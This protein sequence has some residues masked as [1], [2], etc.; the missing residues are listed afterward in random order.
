ML[1]FFS[2]SMLWLRNSLLKKKKTHQTKNNLYVFKPAQSFCNSVT[3]GADHRQ[4]SLPALV[5]SS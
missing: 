4:N 2:F 3:K 1:K 5:T